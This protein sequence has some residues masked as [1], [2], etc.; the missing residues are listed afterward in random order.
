MNQGGLLSTKPFT[1]AFIGNYP[2]RQC[3]IATFNC[4]LL[5]SIEA[6]APEM[7]AWAI[8]MNDVPDGYPYPA[9]VRFE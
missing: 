4:D 1:I 6:E 8:A 3:G 5:R 9:D 2:P 7:D